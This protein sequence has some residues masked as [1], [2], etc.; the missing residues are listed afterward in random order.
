M[1]TVMLSVIQVLELWEQVSIA[2]SAQ[3]FYE[4]RISTAEAL[5]SETSYSDQVEL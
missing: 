5:P 3:G 4:T 2:E 1:F